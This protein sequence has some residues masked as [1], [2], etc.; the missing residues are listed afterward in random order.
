MTA[1]REHMLRVE[2]ELRQ[3]AELSQQGAIVELRSESAAYT[4]LMSPV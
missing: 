2:R 3:Q 4:C 1:R